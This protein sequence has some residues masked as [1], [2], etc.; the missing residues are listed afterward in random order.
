MRYIQIFEAFSKEQFTEKQVLNCIEKGG[1]I[2]A[3]IVN[4]FKGEIPDE[5]EPLSM[6]GNEV[7]VR[8]EN[9]LFTVFLKDIEK[10]NL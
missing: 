10:I 5:L 3:K 7:T 4:D 2:K 6:E 8:I 9:D 1:T